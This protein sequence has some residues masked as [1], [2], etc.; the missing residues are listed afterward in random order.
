[1]LKQAPPGWDPVAVRT[2]DEYIA[3]YVPSITSTKWHVEDDNSFWFEGE[4]CQSK[5]LFIREP[6]D[7]QYSVQHPNFPGGLSTKR[8]TNFKKTLEAA[9]LLIDENITDPKPR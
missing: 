6:A 1:M 5:R 2:L 7:L 9:Y 4:C 8:S 3:E